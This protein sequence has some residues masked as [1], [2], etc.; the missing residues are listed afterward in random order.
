M[1]MMMMMMMMLLNQTPYRFDFGDVLGRRQIDLE[2]GKTASQRRLVLLELR[3]LLLDA[4]DHLERLRAR[5]VTRERT[6]SSELFQQ[7]R[8]LPLELL[9]RRQKTALELV[10][11]TVQYSKTSRHP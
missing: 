7:R 9:A 11:H 1:M 8:H 10:L 3:E 2:D 6:A 5:D 4:G